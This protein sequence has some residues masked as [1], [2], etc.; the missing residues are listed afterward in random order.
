MNWERDVERSI[1]HHCHR[2]ISRLSQIF[3]DRHATHLHSHSY[4]HLLKLS[5]QTDLIQKWKMLERLNEFQRQHRIHR[6]K[7]IV[8]WVQQRWC[9]FSKLH[10]RLKSS[11]TRSGFIH[12][13]RLLSWFFYTNSS[14]KRVY[15]SFFLSL[16]SICFRSVWCL[17]EASASQVICL[18]C[19]RISHSWQCRHCFKLRINRIF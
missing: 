4:S 8:F 15:L 16:P 10:H 13:D 9:L 14:S 18:Y 7:R 6:I 17:S 11:L 12:F 2:C 5:D 19:R 3:R 1:D